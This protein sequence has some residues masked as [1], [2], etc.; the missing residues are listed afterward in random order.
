MISR[1]TKREKKPFHIFKYN[2]KA[3]YH[4]VKVLGMGLWGWVGAK[5]PDRDSLVANM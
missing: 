1:K 2:P 3:K 4:T 5:N